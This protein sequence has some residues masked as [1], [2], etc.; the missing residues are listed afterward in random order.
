MAPGWGMDAETSSRVVDE[1]DRFFP[2]AHDL[3]LLPPAL[4]PREALPQHGEPS[5][6]PAPGLQRLRSAARPEAYESSRRLA[7]ACRTALALEI[8]RGVPFLFVPVFLATGAMLYFAVDFEP[9][10]L[11]M[12]V[13]FAIGLPLALATRGRPAAGFPIA[14]AVLVMAGMLLAKVET[15]RAGTKTLGGEIA[16]TVTG[17]VET[18]DLLANGRT[19]LTI[20]V[21]STARPE[22]RYAPQRI[23]ATARKIPA[24][25]HP[26]ASISGLVRLQ[27]PSG[28]VRPG[29]YDFSF[30]SYFDGIGA[31]GFFLRGP[32]IVPAGP[33]AEAGLGTWV[34]NARLKI[35][36]RIRARIGGA[37]GQIAAA[38]MVGVRA[39]IPE[40]ANE[41]LRRAGLYHIIS[42]SGLH[43]A[44]VAGVIMGG[45]RALLALFPGFSSRRPVRKYAALTAIAAIAFYL[46]ISG[47]E[48]AAQRS[49][50]M[51]AV[52]LVAILFDRAALTM[53]NL[54]ISAIVVII[55]S[56]HEVVGPSFQMSFA[57]TAALVGAYGY[58]SNRQAA[59]DGAPMPGQ[60]SLGMMVMRRAALV[61][62]G[63]AVTSVVA[64]VATAVFGI[65]HFQR[66]SPLSLAANLAAMPVVSLVVV[67]SAVVASLLMPLGLDGPFL[68]LMG[69][70]LA[71][72]IA[73]AQWFSTR[74]PIDAVGL[75]SGWSVILITIALVVA[76]MATT[77]LRIA[78]VPFA[79]IGLA[80]IGHVRTPDILVAEDAALVAMSAGDA[81]LASNRPRPGAFVLENWKR[82]MQTDLVLAPVETEENTSGSADPRAFSCT[83]GLCVATHHT[84]SVVVHT[85]DVEKARKAC[86]FARVI[87][88][89]DPTVPLRCA[90]PA[91]LVV[92]A[93]QL[94]RHGSA[95]I[96]LDGAEGGSPP[97]IAFAI[98]VADRPWHDHR[99]FSRAARGIPPYKP[100]PKPEQQAPDA[101][102]VERTTPVDRPASAAQ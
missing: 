101:A 60:Q 23:R 90:D 53:R 31:T 48:V 92:T 22:L 3:P 58:W 74:S 46:F 33:S 30:E 7:T 82:A 32:D 13:A 16:T 64:G 11:V 8:D 96:H 40:D 95:A 63:L 94:A 47:A 78:A 91:V 71:A 93:R 51:L 19:R 26:G 66:V 45:A 41:A 6:P 49:F 12:M 1:R 56:P 50:I 28:P 72:M 29:S 61:T 24:T 54:A 97:G 2:V 17:R 70:G 77:W 55:L 75:I 36:E 85:A 84:G 89:N 102:P 39:G 9:S 42:I 35:A 4:T 18:I 86:R 99:R 98:A 73:I 79:L 38:L 100:K 20:A 80:T 57:A 37:E 43:M 21:Q 88:L 44:L 5:R 76:T 68:D 65:Y 27:P 10:L 34:E 59:R 83:D 87:V 25:L 52:M 81:A 62:A 67:P 69:K 14:A 15:L